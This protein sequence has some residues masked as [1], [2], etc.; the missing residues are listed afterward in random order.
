MA[1][2]RRYWREAAELGREERM[3]EK[4]VYVERAAVMLP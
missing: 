2:S 4:E 3:D 1:D